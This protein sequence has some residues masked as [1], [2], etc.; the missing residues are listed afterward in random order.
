MKIKPLDKK[1][2]HHGG[3]DFNLVE[4][5]KGYKC[6]NETPHCKI[7]GAMNKLP[8]HNIWRC[9]AEYKGNCS[10]WVPKGIIPIKFIERTCMSCCQEIE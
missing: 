10:G 4:L 3:G 1:F 9:F 7:H 5:K 8:Q 6:E 2:E